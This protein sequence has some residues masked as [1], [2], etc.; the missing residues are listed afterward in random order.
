MDV[1][2][3]PMSVRR[4]LS[5]LWTAWYYIRAFL[6]E[7]RREMLND[8]AGI[9]PNAVANSSATPHRRCLLSIASPNFGFRPS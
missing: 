6:P 4:L 7:V 2:G 5:S 3:M 9:S 8:V 1:T